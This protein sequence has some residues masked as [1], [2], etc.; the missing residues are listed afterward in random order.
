MVR[1][2]K[3][4]HIPRDLSSEYNLAKANSFSNATLHTL[5]S[6]G[7]SQ[8]QS[9]PFPKLHCFRPPACGEHFTRSYPLIEHKLVC[10]CIELLSRPSLSAEK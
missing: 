6:L 5:K 7:E 10:N 9:P 3:I 8:T 1:L 2:K 4:A